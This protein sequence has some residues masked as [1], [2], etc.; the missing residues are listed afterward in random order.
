MNITKRKKDDDL[1]HMLLNE[2]D[3]RV[4]NTLALVQA[5]ARKTFKRAGIDKSIWDAFEGRLVSMSH[6]HSLLT[7]QSWVG[8]DIADIVAEGLIAHGGD[9]ADCFSISGPPAWV[10]A[11]TALALAMAFHELG[12][13]SIKYGALSTPHGRVNIT[14]QIE[15]SETLLILNLNWTESG[16]P[17][18]VAPKRHGFGTQL[19]QQAFCHTGTDFAQVTYPPTGVEFHV[20]FNLKSRTAKSDAA[21]PIPI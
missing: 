2:L 10:D 19:I 16:G 17:P 3:H 8:A 4:K 12:T 11:Q 9:R 7:R 14:W 20:R 21:V 15:S 6:A 13:N 5:M 1:R 18:V